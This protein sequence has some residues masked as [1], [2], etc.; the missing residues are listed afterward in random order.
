MNKSKIDRLLDHIESADEHLKEARKLF[1]NEALTDEER[2]A[3][4]G[5]HFG[6]AL[7]SLIAES[8]R[9]S[10]SLNLIKIFREPEKNKAF[11]ETLNFHAEQE[12]SENFTESLIPPKPN[13]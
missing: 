4:E 13:N 6:S 2:R 8:E 5:I 7:W 11:I 1:R 12:G 3:S 9:A 10:Q